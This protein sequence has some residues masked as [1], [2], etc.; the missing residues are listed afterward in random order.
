MLSPQLIAGLLL[1]AGLS[2]VAGWLTAFRNRH[3]LGLLG[4]AFLSL[5]ASLL[6]GAKA[7]E[8]REFGQAVGRL[9]FWGKGLLLVFAVLVVCAMV[10][11]VS[12]T[13]RRIRELQESHRAAE[14][15]LLEIFKASA[16]KERGA[17]RP[18]A[19]GEPDSKQGE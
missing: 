10:A 9:A 2:M 7:K 6:C 5:S 12:E 3:Y 18:P 13:R 15:A 14:E 17:E 1:I 16:A 4:L 19:D 8:A 11:A